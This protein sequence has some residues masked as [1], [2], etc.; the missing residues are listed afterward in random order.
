MSP[1]ATPAGEPEL[2]IVIPIY[3]EEGILR[4][5]ALGLCEALDG[6]GWSYELLLCENGSTDQTVA[7]G[8]RLQAERPEISIRSSGEPNYGKAMRQ[9]ILAARGRLVICDEIDLCDVDFHRRAVAVLR[10]GDADMVI[11]SKAM[12]GA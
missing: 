12:K 3:N 11:G 5:A 9:G 4:E 1:T 6:L 8:E 10:A 7:I 2:S